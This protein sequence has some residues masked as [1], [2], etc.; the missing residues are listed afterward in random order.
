V[1]IA[2]SASAP[3]SAMVILSDESRQNP[4]PVQLTGAQALPACDIKNGNLSFG[5]VEDR[6]P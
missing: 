6:P 3:D 2:L 5:P 4:A 1:V